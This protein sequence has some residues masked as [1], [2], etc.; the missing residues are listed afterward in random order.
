MTTQMTTHDN[1]TVQNE[2]YSLFKFILPMFEHVFGK[3]VMAYEMC[4]VVINRNKP[5][6]ITTFNPMKITL[7]ADPNCWNQIAHQLAH[8]LTHYAVRKYTDKNVKICAISAF[9][10]PAANAMSLYILKLCAEQWH[11]CDLYKINP[12]YADVFEKSRAT[13][14]IEV[15]GNKPR[16]YNEWVILDDKYTGKLTSAEQRP[17]VSEMCNHLYDTFVEMPDSIAV[18]IRYPLY[19]RSIPY[20]KLIEENLWM[21]NEPESANFIR[22]ICKIQPTVA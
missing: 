11:K 19:L 18:F 1:W 16:D 8:E 6:P 20:D 10:E 7:Q 15:S 13:M 2:V 17:D 3:E 5:M 21:L 4:S 12:N 9:E 22:R 14:Y